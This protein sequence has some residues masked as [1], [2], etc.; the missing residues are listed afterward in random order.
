MK[1]LL[2]PFFAGISVFTAAQTETQIRNHY[3]AVNKQIAESIEQG[4]EGPL[5]QTQVITNKNQKSWPAV[6][7]YV[8]TVNFWYDDAPD[9][10]SAADR[11][12]KNVLLKVTNSR[13]AG[14][15]M[16]A[17]EE[18]LFKDGKLVFYYSYW[19]E[20]DKLWE[21]RAWFNYKGLLFKSSVKLNEKELTAKELASEEYNDEKP[22][23]ATILKAAK[24]YQ[25]VF[26]S[27]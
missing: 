20:E 2:L 4:Y 10:L 14:A 7:I 6:G 19:A 21:T 22:V 1:R 13:R 9:H 26:L 17:I 15:D 24:N 12:P 18:Y 23:A 8:D 16:R 11:N 25:S 27:L 3:T 5:Y